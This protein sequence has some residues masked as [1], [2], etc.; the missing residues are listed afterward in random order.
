MERFCNGRAT[1]G[2]L[3]LQESFEHI[4][5]RVPG[6]AQRARPLAAIPSTIGQLFAQEPRNDGGNIDTEVGSDGD[7]AS[8]DARLH[9]AV[10]EWL[11]PP[12]NRRILR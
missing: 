12:M 11:L 3:E 9:L 10:K 5:G 6:A 1:A 2:T 8:V 4:G 7:D